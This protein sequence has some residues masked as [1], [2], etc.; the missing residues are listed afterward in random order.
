MFKLPVWVL[1]IGTIAAGA[2]ASELNRHSRYDPAYWSYPGL[3]DVSL[4][5]DRSAT[6]WQVVRESSWPADTRN[7]ATAQVYIRPTC[8]L[9]PLAWYDRYRIAP[10]R[11]QWT[12]A[13]D[14]T[15]S[16]RFG[17]VAT[18]QDQAELDAAARSYL[19]KNRMRSPWAV[20]FVEHR[21][22]YRIHWPGV[23]YNLLS[24]TQ[25]VSLLILAAA[26]IRFLIATRREMIA[27]NRCL[28]CDYPLDGLRDPICPECGT[29]V[30]LL[31]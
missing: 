21:Y 6:G 14:F 9:A 30:Q 13:L 8:W 25:I 31:E 22:V 29:T 26:G 20:V 18:R 15:N 17:N 27:R 11:E 1:L 4:E 3:R 24:L 28:N 12:I 23:A 7:R 2:T 10:V 16:E 5:L 19:A